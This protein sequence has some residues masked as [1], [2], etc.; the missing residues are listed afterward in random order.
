MRK[1]LTITLS[2]F[3]ETPSVFHVDNHVQAVG[4]ARGRKYH[5]IPCNPVG[6]ECCAPTEHS[7]RMLHLHAP[8]C[9]ALA[10]GYHLFAS[11]GGSDDVA[12]TR[13]TV[14]LGYCLFRFARYAS[15]LQFKN[16]ILN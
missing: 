12:H 1:K 9:A 4:A 8:S 3:C 15:K 11:Y 10:R 16:S 5:R 2:C 13:R 7:V 14:A 6:V